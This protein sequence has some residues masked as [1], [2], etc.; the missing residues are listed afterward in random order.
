VPS[1]AITD[2]KL[3]LGQNAF[4]G[5]IRWN[6]APM[7]QWQLLGS[8]ASGAET[9]LCNLVAGTGVS[10]TANAHIIYEPY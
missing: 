8:T 2:A 7:Q 10:T 4:G 5:I 3:N 6:A 1:N 9:M